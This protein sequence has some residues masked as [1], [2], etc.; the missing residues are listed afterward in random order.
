MHDNHAIICQLTAPPST[1][2]PVRSTFDALRRTRLTPHLPHASAATQP[3][4]PTA[5]DRNRY[6]D[7]SLLTYCGIYASINNSTGIPSCLP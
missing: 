6:L 7:A 1:T 2:D 3:R 4:S 5:F